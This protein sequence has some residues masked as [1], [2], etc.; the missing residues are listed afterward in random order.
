M[1]SA[2][3]TV[4][5]GADAAGLAAG[6]AAGAGFKATNFC[7]MSALKPSNVLI[8]AN[9]LSILTASSSPA[10]LDLKN[11]FLAEALNLISSITSP[12]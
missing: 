9:I 8:S 3:G 2:T 7:S 10:F 11:T 1:I 5:S 12:H 6:A 4:V